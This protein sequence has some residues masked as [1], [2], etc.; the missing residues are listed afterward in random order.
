M[1]L[2]A[3]TDGGKSNLLVN[4]IY[5]KREVFPFNRYSIRIHIFSPTAGELNPTWNVIKKDRTG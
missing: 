5:H 4:M 3:A 1:L 2:L